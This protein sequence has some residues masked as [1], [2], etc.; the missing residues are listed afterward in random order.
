MKKDLELLLQLYFNGKATDEQ[1]NTLATIIANTPDELLSEVL[2]NLW[3]GMESN[4]SSLRDF[5]AKNILSDILMQDKK[6]QTK[7]IFFKKPL[8][9]LAAVLLLIVAVIFVMK[10]TLTSNKVSNIK[11]IATSPVINQDVQPGDN[12]AVL[13][14]ADGS[15]IML[16]SSANG[17]V[18]TQGQT[19][20][21]KIDGKLSYSGGT[22]NSEILYNTISTPRGGQ[23]QLQLADGSKVWLN[24]ASS[25]RFTTNFTGPQR[26]VELTGEGYFEVAKNAAKPFIV[27]TNNRQSVEVLGTHFNINTYNDEPEVTTTLLEGSIIVKPLNTN[28]SVMLKPGEQ[29]ILQSSGALA[30]LKHVDLDKV[31]AWKNN[32]FNFNNDNLKTVMRQ[33]SRWYNVDIKY[34]GKVPDI[35]FSG[36]VGR[37]LTLKQILAV[38]EETRV[39]YK[40]SGND[41]LISF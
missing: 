35:Q 31:V 3:N 25:L 12:R 33:I 9:Q 2:N 40:I 27:K 1:Q 4:P 29:S 36:E 24:A 30:T 28:Y 16:D 6:I 11:P 34:E 32:V 5:T 26:V 21:I 7:I 10:L 18:A 41:L 17:N 22:A 8:L 20:I 13:Q 23:Y 19:N 14:L 39:H 15:T 37:N 38:L